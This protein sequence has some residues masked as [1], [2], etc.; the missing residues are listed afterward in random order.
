[1]VPAAAR[2]GEGLV[3]VAEGTPVDTA[4]RLESLHD[5]ILVSAR[6]E[7]EA[8]GTCSRCLRDMTVP[9]EVDI[10]EVFAYP[11][12]EAYEY[13]VRGGQIDCEPLV[14]DTVVL[15][16]PFQ[17][18]CRPECP[19]LDPETGMLR[20]PGTTPDTEPDPRWAALTGFM[21]SEDNG[22]DG[23]AQDEE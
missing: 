1:M 11:S 15:S 14:R 23:S 5:G 21:A 16:L 18:I 12:D 6:I 22:G 7:T 17:P 2:L 20:A 19:G 9:V 8:S 3:S 4:L 13:E 10:Q